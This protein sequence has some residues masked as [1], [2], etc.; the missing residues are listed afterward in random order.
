M[1]PGSTFIRFILGGLVNTGT[2]YVLFLCLTS[3]V[4]VSVAYTMAYISGIALGYIVNVRF[5]FESGASVRTA[6]RFPLVYIVQYAWG[7]AVLS[8]LVRGLGMLPAL[9]M[10][11][12]IGTS[13]PLT[14][15]L[16]RYVLARPTAPHDTAR[17]RAP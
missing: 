3:I 13:V 17:L 14:F 9:A 2:T 16:A 7:L 15:F 5:V 11:V 1:R 8:L 4:S 10:L 12:S 6:V